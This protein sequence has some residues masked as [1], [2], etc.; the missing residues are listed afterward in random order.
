LSSRDTCKSTYTITSN[1]FEEQFQSGPYQAT[2]RQY[3]I[4][5]RK[6]TELHEIT[7]YGPPAECREAAKPCFEWLAS[8]QLYAV[9][10]DVLTVGASKAIASSLVVTLPENF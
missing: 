6:Y 4:S 3:F 1:D 10:R 2:I 8:V 7:L 9:S 5:G